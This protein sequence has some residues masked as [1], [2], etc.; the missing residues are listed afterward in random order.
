MKEK[1]QKFLSKNCIPLVYGIFAFSWELLSLIYFD[2]S[3]KITKPIF[4]CLLLAIGISVICLFQSKLRR[5]VMSTVFLLFQM[6]IA[7]AC[8]YLFLSNGTIFEWSMYN[9][10]NDAYGTVEHLILSRGLVIQAVLM[11]LGYLAFLIF[12]I[13][14]CKKEGLMLAASASRKPL[15]V[16]LTVLTVFAVLYSPK[17]KIGSNDDLYRNLLYDTNNNY[18]ELGLSGNLVY[19]VLHRAPGITVDTEKLETLS[20]TLYH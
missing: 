16:S 8:N 2:L 15:L 5:A 13:R 9:Q 3:P 11:L 19:E 20:E 7:L 17:Q 1:I 4:P 10:R 6:G 12:Y 18:Q 14:H